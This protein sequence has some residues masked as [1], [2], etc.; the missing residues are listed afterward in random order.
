MVSL[1][2]ALDASAPLKITWSGGILFTLNGSPKVSLFWV[3][4]PVL[5]AHN[6]STP[7]NSSIA[8]NRETLSAGLKT[9]KNSITSKGCQTSLDV[10]DP[11]G[12]YIADLPKQFPIYFGW[13]SIRCG[14]ESNLLNHQLHLLRYAQLQMFELG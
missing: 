3:R 4:V 10:L 6:T 2:S 9:P 11:I 12:T 5:S 14:L 8:T 13:I 7:A 1:L